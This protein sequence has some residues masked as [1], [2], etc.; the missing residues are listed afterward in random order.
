MAN[1]VLIHGGGWKKLESE[2]ISS[3][4]FKDMLDNHLGMKFVHDYYGMVEQTGSIFMGM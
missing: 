2:S 3:A 4:K 1:S